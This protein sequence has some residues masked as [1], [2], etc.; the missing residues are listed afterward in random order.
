MKRETVKIVNKN[1]ETGFCNIAKED[2]NEK[3]HTLFEEKP[4]KKEA[5]KEVPKAEEA[6]TEDAK[7]PT[8]KRTTKKSKSEE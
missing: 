7:K 2:F 4:A 6:K 1:S 3:E 8:K 5:K